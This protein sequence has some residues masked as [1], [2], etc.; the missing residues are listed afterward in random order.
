[1]KAPRT[2]SLALA[3][4][5]ILALAV[6]APPVRAH[7]DT[8][9]GPVVSSARVALDK[10]DVTPV[11]RWVKPDAEREVR[12]AF[13]RTLA[14]RGQGGAQTR[15]LADRYFFE[16]VVR[17]HRAGEGEPFTGLKAT[18]DD[19]GGVIAAADAAVSGGSADAL[20]NLVTRQV[21]AGIRERF[22]RV[23]EAKKHASDSVEAGRRYVAAYVEYV[24]YVESVGG[25]AGEA[26]HAKDA[27]GHAVR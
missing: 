7:C 23:V 10:R 13:A 3:A 26:A 1:M 20:V 11:L 27:T 25:G 8:M 5:T 14:V 4:A 24:H 16:T 12:D 15:E 17:L 6:Y 22:A 9:T 18:A 19:P 21:N 2:S